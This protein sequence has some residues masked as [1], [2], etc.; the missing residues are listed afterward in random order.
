MNN[1]YPYA[2]FWK[3]AGAYLI[4]YMLINIATQVIIRIMALPMA[5][6]L[7]ALEKMPENE[8]SWEQLAPMLGWLPMIMI[9]ALIAPLLYFAFMES[10]SKQA[11]LGKMALG[12]KV[13]GLDGG[14]IS[15]WRAVGRKLAKIVS[16]LTF[17]IGYYMAGATRKKQALHDKMVSTYVVDKNFKQG[18]NLPEVEP[19]FGI[20]TGIIIAE[21]LVT[22][23]FIGLLVFIVIAASQ[24]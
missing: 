5:S 11:T 10:S 9:V 14:R 8:I 4:D 18:D 19:H 16:G 1:I 22:L 6:N 20:L 12:I 13:V 2:G 3:R 17:N 24:H 7:Q 23:L 21:V 15:F